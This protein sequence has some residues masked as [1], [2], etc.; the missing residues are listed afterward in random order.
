MSYRNQG[1]IENDNQIS[2]YNYGSRRNYNIETT[3]LEK[4]L[5]FD[6]SML[7]GESS[8]YNLTDLQSCY[9]RYLLNFASIIEEL[10]GIER[11]PIKLFTKVLLVFKHYICTGYSISTDYYGG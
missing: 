4:R 11:A 5:I 10:I 6:N 1:K 2:K 7:T 8:T 9:N 3:I